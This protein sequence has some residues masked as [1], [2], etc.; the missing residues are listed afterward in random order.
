MKTALMVWALAGVAFAQDGKREE[1]EAKLRNMRVTLDFKEAPL[2]S[3]VD[4]LREFSGL[5]IFVD[6]KA[7]EKN[8]VV[9]LKVSDISLKSVFSLILHP[10]GCDTMFREGVLMVMTK[11]DVI[12]RTIKMEIY[13]C[14]DILYPIHDFPGVDIDLGNA[15]G[16][17]ITPIDPGGDSAEVPI[18]E[19][20]RAHTGGRSWEENQK[21]VCKMTNGLLVIKNT[22]EVHKQVN[23]LLD[24]LRRNK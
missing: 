16:I 22:P 24:M 8:I 5:N 4:Y 17:L 11:E 3:V 15:Q 7:K 14:R 6:G 20:V 23:R 12:D 18:E 13:D 21:C 1:V 2:E 9:S 19:L 10:H